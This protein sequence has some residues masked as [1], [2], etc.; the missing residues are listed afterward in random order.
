MKLA[1]LVLALVG[2]AG[3]PYSYDPEGAAFGRAL[4]AVP[5]AQGGTRLLAAGFSAIERGR[6]GWQW[7]RCYPSLWSFEP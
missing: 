4:V 2:W 3:R 1:A 7:L 6:K 5:R